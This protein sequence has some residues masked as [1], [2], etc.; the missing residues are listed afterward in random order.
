[1][2]ESMLGFALATFAALIPV[3]DPLG[4][5]PLFYSLTNTGTTAYREHQARWTTFHVIWVLAL[6]LVAGKLILGFFGISLAVLRIAGGLLIAQTGWEMFS[7]SHSEAEQGSSGSS[8]IAFAP[9]AVPLVSGP[10][11]IGVVIGLSAKTGN[12][13]DYIGCLFGIILLGASL[14]L[15]LRLGEP[16][17]KALGKAGSSALN[18]ILGFLIVA[19]ALQF[20]VDGT[21]QLIQEAAPGLL[22]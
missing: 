3:S 16:L 20:I 11:A 21:T 15:C 18:Q 5:V 14:Y 19:L 2:L 9:M 1:V 4:A 13:Y 8:D 10:G 12:W 6:F 22:H 7:K 17:L